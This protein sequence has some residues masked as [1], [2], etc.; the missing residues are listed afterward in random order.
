MTAGETK[1]LIDELDRKIDA[2]DL[3]DAWNL[4]ARAKSALSALS[5]HPDEETRACET[6]GQP[7]TYRLGMPTPAWCDRHGPQ[8]TP[9]DEETEWEWG[10]SW[11]EGDERVFMP[12]ENDWRAEVEVNRMNMGYEFPDENYV[13]RRRKAGPWLPVPA[14]G[15]E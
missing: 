10:A 8:P 9:P 3:M 1:A 6:C 14:T 4:M 13:V 7:A 12:T 2:C 15:V 5:S 11:L